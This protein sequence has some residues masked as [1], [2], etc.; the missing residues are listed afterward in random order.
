MGPRCKSRR[1]FGRGH[2]ADEG[3]AD[4][5]SASSDA[6]AVDLAIVE[7]PR[8]RGAVVDQMALVVPPPKLGGGPRCRQRMQADRA[9][10]AMASAQPELDNEIGANLVK[11]L[12]SEIVVEAAQRDLLQ[13]G[14]CS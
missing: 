9:A 6:A 7:P 5:L 13:L 4:G 12:P 3:R 14:H 10:V 8:V 1:K 11:R 2:H